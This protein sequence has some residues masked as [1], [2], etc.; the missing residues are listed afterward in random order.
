MA[1]PWMRTIAV[2]FPTAATDETS[3]ACSPGSVQLYRSCS[4][5]SCRPSM[6]TSSSTASASRAALTAALMLLSAES[7]ATP[8]MPTVVPPALALAIVSSGDAMHSYLLE[9]Q[10]EPW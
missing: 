1:P 2:G 8:S 3:L 6:P 5:P 9:A 10:R 4:S 7:T